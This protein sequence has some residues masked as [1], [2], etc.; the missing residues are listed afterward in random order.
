MW[1]IR[2]AAYCAVLSRSG[3]VPLN[4]CGATGDGLWDGSGHYVLMSCQAE[5]LSVDEW[6]HPN[7]KLR[8]PT[9]QTLRP[10]TSLNCKQQ[11]LHQMPEHS[12][13]GRRQPPVEKTN[14]N[15]KSIEQHSVAAKR[16]N[17]P[18]PKPKTRNAMLQAYGFWCIE[19][20]H[21]LWDSSKLRSLFRTSFAEDF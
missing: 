20:Q 16:C 6:Y 19:H 7:P 8:K 9:K 12:A 1:A 11:R 3:G 14:A 2:K 5:T 21:C 15:D 13:E 4:S 17:P 10:A 18:A